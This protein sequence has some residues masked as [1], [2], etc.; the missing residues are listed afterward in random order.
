MTLVPRRNV[1]LQGFNTLAVPCTAARY[2][3]IAG[4][5][6]LRE[7]LLLAHR[8]HCPLLVLGGGSNV[9]LPE[10]FRGLVL[11]MA[12]KGFELIAQGPQSVLVRAGAGEVWQDLVDYSLERDYFGLE[13]LSLI[14]G[15]VGAAPIQNIGAYGVELDSVFHSL[16]AIDRCSGEPVTFNRADCDFR[17]RDSAFK[18]AL[19]DRYVITHVTFKLLREPRL[20]LSYTPLREALEEVPEQQLNARMVSE[21]VCA[22]RRSKLPDPATIPNAGSFFKNPIVDAETFATLKA[23]HP[24]VVS[25]PAG[26][27][28]VKIAAGWLL[29]R[30]GW[31]GHSD[32]GLGM[33]INQAL[34]LVNPGRRSGQA[35]LTYAARLQQDIEERFG[36]RLERE[37]VAY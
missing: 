7:A 14:P 12:I 4:L 29:D 18:N 3:A 15:T 35:V 37:P 22:I 19:K 33:H 20:N 32:A 26:E 27:G 23:T 13:N 16:E 9:V 6:Q 30:A 21:A 34:V 2:V 5:Q 10:T 25:Y 36:I 8:E 11:H 24:D 17:Y 28:K 1:S 31:R